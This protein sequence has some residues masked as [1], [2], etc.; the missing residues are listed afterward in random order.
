[1]KKDGKAAIGI[2]EGFTYN[3]KEVEHRDFRGVSSFIGFCVKLE[4]Q[5][6]LPKWKK[7]A[8]DDLGVHWCRKEGLE[9]DGEGRI[10]LRVGEWPLWMKKPIGTSSNR[11]YNPNNDWIVVHCY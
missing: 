3:G 2:P 1:M 7:K 11:T 6:K 8:L 9:D 5:G 10:V 4:G